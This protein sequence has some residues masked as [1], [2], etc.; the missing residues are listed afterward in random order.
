[1]TWNLL[2]EEC[3]MR[4]SG[5]KNG[6]M[7]CVSPRQSGLSISR[8]WGCSPQLDSDK[9]QMWEHR[10]NV[11]W[12]VSW[13]EFSCL[14]KKCRKITA[15]YDFILLKIPGY[16]SVSL[17]VPDFFL[18]TFRLNS[19]SLKGNKGQLHKEVAFSFPEHFEP[20]SQRILLIDPWFRLS[21]FP[22]KVTHRHSALESSGMFLK[23]SHWSI[24]AIYWVNTM[25]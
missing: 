6:Y 5:D 22:E 19:A 18:L 21:T 4:M 8:V 2:P 23:F 13:V 24:K 25:W 15:S 1:M 3:W 11:N 10:C 17:L 20:W 9:C 12:S 14:K 7:C 16:V